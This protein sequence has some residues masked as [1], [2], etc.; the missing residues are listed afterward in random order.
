MTLAEMKLTIKQL[1]SH[2]NHYPSPNT[3]QGPTG[4]DRRSSSHNLYTTVKGLS[5]HIHT[6][7]K[8]I[9][10]THIQLITT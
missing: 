5:L 9:A 7:L 8:Q 1:H 4:I 10:T 3:R 6:F 2:Y